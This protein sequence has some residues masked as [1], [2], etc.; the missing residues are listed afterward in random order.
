MT[1]LQRRHKAM[2]KLP[3]RHCLLA[4]PKVTRPKEL[5]GLGIHDMQNLGW[6][7][8]ARCPWLQET[9]PGKPQA[10]FYIQI[11]REIQCLIDMAMVTMVG[12]D[13]NT[14]FWKD[15]WQNGQRIAIVHALVPKRI[16]NKCKVNE[17]LLN[18]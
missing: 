6:A 4:W 16:V 7:L 14:L 9:E 1:K 15:R 8:R 3:R 2:T 18:I 17:A 13:A 5:G 10:Q 11:S 12:D